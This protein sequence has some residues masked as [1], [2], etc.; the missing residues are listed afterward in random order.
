MEAEMNMAT[1]TCNTAM[2]VWVDNSSWMDW[3]GWSVW[4]EVDGAEWE[5]EWNGV[6]KKERWL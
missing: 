6:D 1:V 4:G 2:R 5:V 3:E